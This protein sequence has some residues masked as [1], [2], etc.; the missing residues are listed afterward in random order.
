MDF[1]R[2]YMTV[3]YSKND[4]RG[5]KSNLT[6]YLGLAVAACQL[7]GSCPQSSAFSDQ[8]KGIAIRPVSF[9]VKTLRR[10]D[11]LEAFVV[12]RLRHLATV[13]GFSA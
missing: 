9:S 13:L 3:G 10:L 7:D 2:W 5:I 4:K 1:R 11:L 12:V 6:G 8:I